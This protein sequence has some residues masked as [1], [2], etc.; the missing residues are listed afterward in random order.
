MSPAEWIGNYCVHQRKGYYQSLRIIAT[1]AGE[2]NKWARNYS[3][4]RLVHVVALHLF[5][6]PPT[7]LFLYYAS[8]YV[9]EVVKF[10]FVSFLE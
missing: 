10:F 1:Y 7:A 6:L 4:A 2:E 8:G 5:F 9:I 3:L